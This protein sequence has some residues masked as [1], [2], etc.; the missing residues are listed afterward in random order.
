MAGGKREKKKKDTAS[1]AV[2]NAIAQKDPRC[3]D[4][5]SCQGTD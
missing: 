1:R 3:I 4:P 2:T 5:F